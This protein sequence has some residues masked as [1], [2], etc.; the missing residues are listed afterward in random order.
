MN[1]NETIFALSS[2]NGKSGVAVVRISGNCL[3]K[4][5][6]HM[7]GNKNP[8]QSR[9]A[10]LTNLMDSNAQLIDQ[11]VAIYFKAPNS[12]TGE[13]VI[14]LHTHGAPAVIEKLFQYLASLGMRMAD[15]G[16]FSRRAFYNNKMDLAEVDGLAA[17]LDART[18]R[19]RQNALRSMTGSDSAIYDTWRAQMIEIA[20]YS[21]AILDYPADELPQ[22]IGQK[23]C[24]QTQKLYN[25]INHA[26]SGYARSRAIRS[27]FNIALVG[28]T[29]VGKSSLFNRLVGSARA[30]VSDIPGTTRDVVSAEL[31]IN[32]YLVH[33]SDTA[34]LR[35]SDDTIEKIGIERTHQTVENADLIL[36]VYTPD[37]TTRAPVN[38]NEIIVINK[39]DLINKKPESESLVFVSAQTGDGIDK[40]MT[41]IQEKISAAL[42]GRESDIAVNERTRTLLQ[43]AQDE[44]KHA[45][46]LSTGNYDLFA[47]HVRTAS[48]D[49]GKILG[50]ISVNE[51]ADATF[52]QLCLGK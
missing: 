6:S 29:N 33:L 37:Q 40:L 10:Y 8:I 3:D 38:A 5:F 11:C 45:L 31:D 21:A 1:H 51:I 32:G 22:N 44:L 52:G 23:L 46:D 13:D 9:H 28:Q 15:R 7:I 47:E 49:I 27:G 39:S 30:I 48:D 12:F 41:A 16:E 24:D 2:G 25:E 20:A 42:D 36:R 35:Q 17:L 43:H 18:D 34:G 26:I 4:T 19:Q 14:E 50:A